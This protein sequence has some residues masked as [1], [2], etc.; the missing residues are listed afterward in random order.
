MP[1]LDKMDRK[2]L[3]ALQSDGRLSNAALAE[4]VG[5]S[6]TPCWRR[7]K[8]LEDEG[9]ITGYTAL[10]DPV[11]LS[12]ADSV[13][14]QVTLEK[15][16]GVALDDFAEQVK[17]MP[18]VVDAFVV[19]GQADYWLR[20]VVPNSAGYENFLSNKLLKVPG[21]AHVH[22]AYVLKQVKYMSELPIQV[23]GD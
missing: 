23:D 13:F 4:R 11:K 18:E 1:R 9:F 6:P 15:H 7:V 12:L 14:A 8:K 17:A 10:V 19:A 22:S 2:I 5:L 16:Q 3:R 20:V 21:V